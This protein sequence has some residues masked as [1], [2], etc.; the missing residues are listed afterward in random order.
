DLGERSISPHRNL[1]TENGLALIDA[2]LAAAHEALA[3]GNAEA[4][5]TLIARASR[6]MRYWKAR[7]ETAEISHPDPDSDV[8]R[9]GMVVTI[10]D[11]N[12]KSQVWA[13]VGEDEADASHGKISHVSPI[14]QLMFGKSVGDSFVLN[15][16][17]WEITA[18]ESAFPDA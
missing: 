17:E 4:D 9:F 12:D 11:E 1:V 13:I 7:R 14:A 10:A 5:R 2:E 6:D 15:D 16:H 3:R 18:I 8:V